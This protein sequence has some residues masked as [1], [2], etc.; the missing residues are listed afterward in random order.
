MLLTDSHHDL[1]LR[2]SGPL[3]HKLYELNKEILMHVLYNYNAVIHAVRLLVY[4]IILA[5]SGKCVAVS[6][7]QNIYTYTIQ[8]H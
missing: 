3:Y 5:C 4:I 2:L 1:Q 7:H 6:I 8:H